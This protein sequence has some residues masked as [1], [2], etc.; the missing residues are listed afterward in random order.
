ACKA[1]RTRIPAARR[2]SLLALAMLSAPLAA[3]VPPSAAAAATAAPD[4]CCGGAQQ[5]TP[6]QTPQAA[7]EPGQRF[8]LQ[9]VVF[10]GASM[11]DEAELQALAADY[12][13]R[14]VAFDDLQQIAQRVTDLYLRRGYYLAQAVL[15]VQEVVDG[16][17]EIS[18]V[19]GRL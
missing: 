9:Q 12:V 13:G 7:D 5:Q 3:Q 6:Q 17:V 18:V 14:Q 2:W 4:A 16:V 19:E 10:K 1:S 11:I 8:V 15:P